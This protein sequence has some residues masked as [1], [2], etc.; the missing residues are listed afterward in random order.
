MQPLSLPKIRPLQ[1][2]VRW[3]PEARQR[4]AIVAPH[5]AGVA[6]NVGGRIAASLRGSRATETP[7]C[8]YSG[9]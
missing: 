7:P 3:R 6:D 2:P 8:V 5:E 4:A 1:S 9:A